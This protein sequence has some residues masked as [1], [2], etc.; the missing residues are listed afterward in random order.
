MRLS[1]NTV[2]AVVLSFLNNALWGNF[3]FIDEAVIPKLTLPLR[4]S[5]VEVYIDIMYSC[6]TGLQV[7]FGSY[8][9]RK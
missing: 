8:L 4:L 9:I 2:V 3:N 7:H 1:R 6:D 5:E